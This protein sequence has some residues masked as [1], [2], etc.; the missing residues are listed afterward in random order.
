M[1]EEAGIVFNLFF[2]AFNWVLFINLQLWRIILAKQ[3]L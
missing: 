3:F 1:W 2:L